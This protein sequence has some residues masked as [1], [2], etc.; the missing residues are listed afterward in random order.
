MLWK[1][2]NSTRQHEALHRAP[3]PPGKSDTMAFFWHFSHSL[4][5][6]AAARWCWHAGHNSVV[7]FVDPGNWSFPKAAP[8][9]A[10]LGWKF[11]RLWAQ[12]V[13]GSVHLPS[14]PQLLQGNEP[15]IPAACSRS[16]L[17]K[18]LVVW[19]V[20]YQLTPFIP[21]RKLLLLWSGKE[22]VSGHKTIK[23]ILVL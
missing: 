10:R 17:H 9:P 7:W 16:L 2:R 21:V 13:H 23:K 15:F 6:E 22:R 4:L 14:H 3:F 8:A 19:L 11:A 12:K 5:R 20:C 18:A 1:G